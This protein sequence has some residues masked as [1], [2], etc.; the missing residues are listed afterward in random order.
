[1]P[2]PLLTATELAKHFS[3]RRTQVIKMAETGQIPSIDASSGCSPKYRFS[4]EEVAEALSQRSVQNVRHEES[5]RN[6]ASL[7]L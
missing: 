6:E 1:M 5:T 3:F 7:V 2:K 4:L